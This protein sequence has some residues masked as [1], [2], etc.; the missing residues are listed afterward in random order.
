MSDMESDK[1]WQ[2]T[3][4]EKEKGIFVKT[5]REEEEREVTR[6]NFL[7]RFRFVIAQFYEARNEDKT[8]HGQMRTF[9]TLVLENLGSISSFD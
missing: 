6:E 7:C 4:Q 9:L 1:S 3:K 2:F 5:G 8:D